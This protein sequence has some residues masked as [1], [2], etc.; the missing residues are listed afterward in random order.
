MNNDTLRRAVK[1]A[2]GWEW[3]ADGLIHGPWP[4]PEWHP[5][6]LT[7]LDQTVFLDALAAQLWK[8]ANAIEG[9]DVV[10]EPRKTTV[11]QF[12]DGEPFPHWIQVGRHEGTDRS[13][14]D[15]TAIVES[16][17]LE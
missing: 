17:V 3:T 6:D 13:E 1:L 5:D 15:I 14:N 10:S 2:D 16:G 4:L 8:Q 12:T 9:I 11:L 7:D